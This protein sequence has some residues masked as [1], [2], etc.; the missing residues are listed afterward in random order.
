VC[1]AGWYGSKCERK[2]GRCATT[3]PNC[4]FITGACQA[5]EIGWIGDN[6]DELQLTSTSPSTKIPSSTHI[7]DTGRFIKHIF[8]L[9]YFVNIYKLAKKIGVNL[10]NRPIG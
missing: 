2:C 1:P 6:C 3:Y 10:C 5:C 8:K 4:Q 7:P 9:T